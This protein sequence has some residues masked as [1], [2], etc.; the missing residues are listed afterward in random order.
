MTTAIQ[1]DADGIA[2][3]SYQVANE[4]FRFMYDLLQEKGAPGS[5]FW[6]W[7]R[8]MF[9]PRSMLCMP[10][11]LNGS[12]PPKKDV[13]WGSGMAED[14]NPCQKPERQSREGERLPQKLPESMGESDVS[15][16]RKIPVIGLTEQREV[17]TDR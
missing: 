2:V 11:V 4:F 12:I 6:W 14:M 8:Y 16:E 7:W 9:L 13:I 17:L 15:G 1:E 5:N 3:S 10:M